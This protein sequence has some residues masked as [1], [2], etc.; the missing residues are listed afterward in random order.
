MGQHRH[1]PRRST[2][3][4]AVSPRSR[5]SF[6]GLL[7]STFNYIFE[8]QLEKLQDGDRFYYLPRTDGLNLLTQLED[9]L[10][11][12]AG[13]AQHRPGGPAGRHLL[14]PDV[15]LLRAGEPRDVG[16]VLDD[17]ATPDVNEAQT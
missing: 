14:A 6:G 15:R 11:L 10:V 13:A 16:P 12:R 9:E 2:S 5:S 7:G 1:R 8:T 4:S 3:G 17:P